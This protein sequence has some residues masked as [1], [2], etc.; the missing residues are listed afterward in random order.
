MGKSKNVR[1]AATRVGWTRRMVCREAICPANV[2]VCVKCGVCERRVGRQV[3][4][5]PCGDAS[6]FQ[7]VTFQHATTESISAG[8][9]ISCYSGAGGAGNGCV[10]GWQAHECESR[11]D[12]VDL[13]TFPPPNLS[14]SLNRNSTILTANSLLPVCTYRCTTSPQPLQS[15]CY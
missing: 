5:L 4:F 8:T 14:P 12:L 2:C 9:P 3:L 13:L 1:D 15:A 11:L 10:H 7:I 6:G